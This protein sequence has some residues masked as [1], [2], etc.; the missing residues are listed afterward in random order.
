M[1]NKETFTK[2]TCDFCKLYKKWQYF[3]YKLIF[4]TYSMCFQ[5]T[6]KDLT[7][8]RKKFPP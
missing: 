5:E 2:K 6:I 7:I 4:A 8:L 3:C 1:F